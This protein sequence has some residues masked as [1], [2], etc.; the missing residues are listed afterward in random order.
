MHEI[1]DMVDIFKN[2]SIPF[3]PIPVIDNDDLTYLL[4]VVNTRLTCIKSKIE[5]D[6]KIK[7][8]KRNPEKI[9]LT[10][11]ILQD[12]QLQIEIQ[13]RPGGRKVIYLHID[14]VTKVKVSVKHKN[15]EL[16][17]DNG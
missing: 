6:K 1:F 15:F 2:T 17:T 4:E 9:P 7:L 14:G 12:E 8:N 13:T 5:I 10:D 11:L 16:V 3:V